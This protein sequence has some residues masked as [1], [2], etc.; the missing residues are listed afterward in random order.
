MTADGAASWLSEIT[1]RPE[2]ECA[3]VLSEIGGVSGLARGTCA[4]FWP[5]AVSARVEAA[6]ALGRATCT[7]NDERQVLGSPSAAAKFLIPSYGG[8]AVERC[9]VVVLDAKHRV[10][11]TEVLTQG[12]ANHCVLH[13]REVF[14][15]GIVWR[16]CGVVLFH[17]HPSGDP[18]P[19]QEDLAMTKRL[20]EAGNV[21]GIEVLDSL[22]LTAT[23]YVSL[24]ESGRL[25]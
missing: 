11:R 6:I 2:T 9:G 21:I 24:R 22:V 23:S 20:M 19:S 25:S 1:R 12:T 3:R 7:E 10:L 16:G 8:A 17:N 14:R 5:A 15:V 18:T 4:A 13:P